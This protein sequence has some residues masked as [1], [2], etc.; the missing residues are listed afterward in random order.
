MISQEGAAFSSP[1]RRATPALGNAANA[2]AWVTIRDFGAL[3][4]HSLALSRSEAGPAGGQESRKRL[5]PTGMRD[6]R[7]PFPAIT[8]GAFQ[9]KYPAGIHPRIHFPEGGRQAAESRSPD[10][11]RRNGTNGRTYAGTNRGGGNAVRPI[12]RRRGCTRLSSCPTSCRPRAKPASAPG[13]YRFANSCNRVQ[14]DRQ[15]WRC[16]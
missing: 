2:T 13:G 14:C 3:P 8:E 15:Y 12:P 6:H 7:D 9:V 4:S 10:A 1:F 16:E 5:W 11:F